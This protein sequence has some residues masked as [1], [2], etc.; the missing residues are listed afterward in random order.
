MLSSRRVFLGLVAGAVG[1]RPSIGVAQG[2]LDAFAAQ[3]LPCVLDV[4]ATPAV[5]RDASYRTGAP[6]RTSIVGPGQKGIPLEVTG[7]VAGLSCGPIAGAVLEF[8]QPD[9][10]GAYDPT[11]FNLRGR[12][13]TDAGGRYRLTTIVPGTSG[14]RAPSIGVHVVVE[15]KAEL[16]T[17]IFFPGQRA[18]A[19][20]ARFKDELLV[21]L[22][23]SAGK[24]TATFDVRLDL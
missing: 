2:G 19:R 12:Q 15:R 17:A 22:G 23:G 1:A 16:W 10:A 5:S 8:W 24:R 20:D 3:T 18:N 14:S 6:P 9:A 7:V 13:M 11:G 21:K 4:K